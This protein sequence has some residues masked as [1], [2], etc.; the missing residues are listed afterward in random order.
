VCAFAASGAHV[1]AKFYVS[2][3]QEC[4]TC[5]AKP[6]SPLLC[7]G[8]IHNHNEQER[9][10]EALDYAQSIVQ[11]YDLELREAGLAR[12]GFC[13]GVIFKE[14]PERIMQLRYGDRAAS[15]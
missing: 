9:F 15:A 11:L 1:R 5:R 10:N 13:Q 12:R 2:D 3:F 4:D 14:A 6:G 8:C 7:A